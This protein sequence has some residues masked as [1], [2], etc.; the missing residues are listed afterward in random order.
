MTWLPQRGSGESSVLLRE[1]PAEVIQVEYDTYRSRAVSQGD[2]G[3]AV[4]ADASQGASFFSAV[5]LALL[6]LLH[7]G[8]CCCGIL[9]QVVAR[10]V[11]AIMGDLGHSLTT[12][13]A[14]P[15]CNVVQFGIR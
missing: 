3:A 10:T 4:R 8:Y 15:T 9:F 12:F 14:L 6:P 7:L 2:A 5:L 1:Y 11:P 13:K